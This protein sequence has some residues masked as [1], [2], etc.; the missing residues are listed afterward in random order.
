MGKLKKIEHKFKASVFGLSRH[1]MQ[2]TDRNFRP[3]DGK[4]LSKVLFLRPEKIGDL[5]ISLPAFDALKKA[6]PHIQISMLASPKNVE[7]IKDDPRFSRI[8]LYRKNILKD[9]AALRAIRKERFDCVVDMICDDSV[10]ALFLAQW[11]APGKPRIGIGKHRFRDYY[12][13]NYDH[14]EGN[15]GHIIDNSLKLLDAFGIDSSKATGYAPP[16]ISAEATA[17]AEQ[18]LASLPA[19]IDGSLRIGYNISAGASSRIWAAEKSEALLRRLLEQFDGAQIIVISVN[20]DRARGDALVSKFSSNV[21]QV[22]P[23]LSLMEASALVSKLDLLV[24]PD[25]ATVHIARSFHIPVVGM[26][27]HYHTN[28]LL[29]SPYGQPEGAVVSQDDGNIFDITVDQVYDAVMKIIVK[30]KQAV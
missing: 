8:F 13:F 29:W 25:T 26:Y 7:L 24:S 27:C 17:T 22:P 3:L 14:R 11:C 30:K 18:F 28:F 2:R 9:L 12:D 6:Y 5:V 15:T 21:I 20:S 4:A 23:G 10:T 1:F 16:Y 19:R